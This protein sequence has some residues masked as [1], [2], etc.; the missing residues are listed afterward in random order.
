[1]DDPV[2][3]NV[4]PQ[5]LVYQFQLAPVPSDPPETLSVTRSPEQ[6]DV[7]DDVIDAGATELV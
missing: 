4:P 7:E 3:A 5:L 6:T 1:M 2:P